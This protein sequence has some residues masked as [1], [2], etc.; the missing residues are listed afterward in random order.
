MTEIEKELIQIY[1]S[2]TPEENKRIEAYV[3]KIK[4]ERT[5]RE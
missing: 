1:M 2:I 3:E 4:R 5:E